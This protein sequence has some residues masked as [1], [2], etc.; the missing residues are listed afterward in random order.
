MPIR[1][2]SDERTA[3]NTSQLAKDA[4]HGSIL[5]ARCLKTFWKRGEEF[6]HHFL[7]G[8]SLC[9]V[10][11]STRIVIV[12]HPFRIDQNDR[13]VGTGHAH[14]RAARENVFTCK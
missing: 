2:F 1:F 10:S 3:Q 4:I 9:P 8:K 11:V 12:G 13:T 7:A 6:A 5:K 14:G